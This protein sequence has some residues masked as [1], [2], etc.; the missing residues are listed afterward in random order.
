M[1]LS[2][3]YKRM[4]HPETAVT[5]NKHMAPSKD[6]LQYAVRLKKNSTDT[7]KKDSIDMLLRSHATSSPDDLLWSFENLKSTSVLE[8]V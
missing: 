3:M 2:V 6:C 7:N 8:T 5:Q 1:A 4:L